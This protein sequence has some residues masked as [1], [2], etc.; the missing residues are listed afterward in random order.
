MSSSTV[1]PGRSRA[2]P[3][4]YRLTTT[5]SNGAIAA[6][7][8]LAPV[9][10]EAA[11]GQDPA[12][13][14][15]VERLDPAV[16]H[17]GRSRSRRPRRSPAG[18][19]RATPAPCRRSRPARS[20]ARRGRDPRSTSPVLSETDSSARRGTGTRASAR[21][22]STRHAPA[23]DDQRVGQEQRD[24]PRQ[25]PVLDGADPVVEGR[26]VVAGQDRHGLLRDDRPTVERR[27]DEVDR[28]AGHGRAVRQRVR[29]GMAARERRQQRRVRVEDPSRRTPPGPPA[30]RSACT[31][32]ARPRRR[33]RPRASRRASRRRRPGRAPSRSPAPPPSRAPGRR[34]RRRRGR[35]RRRAPRDRPPAA[36][37]R[38]FEPAPDTP[39][40]IRPL[41]RR[42]RAAP[43]RSGRR[44]PPRSS[45]TSPTTDRL[46]PERPDRLD[47]RRDGVARQH[48]DHAEPAVERRP[49]LRVVETAERPE[50]AHDRRHR[51]ARRVEPRRET[52]RQRARHVAG[53]AAAGDVGDAVEVEAQRS[54]RGPSREDRLRRRSVSASAGSRRASPSPRA[55]RRRGRVGRGV[56]ERPAEP[57]LVRLARGR[58][59]TAPA[60]PGPARSRSSGGPDEARPRMTSPAR[61][62]EPSMT[63]ARSTTPMQQPDRSKASVGHEVRVLRRLAADQRAAGVATAGRDRADELGDGLRDDPPDGDVVEEGERLGAAAHDVVGA[64]RHEVDA[65]RVEP[66]EGE[67]RS[68]SWCRRRRSR[69]RSAARGSRPGS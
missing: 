59:P 20:R 58:A 34:D 54:R 66:P 57:R 19:R 27:V 68:R 69:R 50:Q 31:R 65:D 52:V 10:G 30:R 42:P 37:A 15:R 38:R 48:D 7:S 14:P 35:S 23:I 46:D 3:N 18:R 12:V 36:S 47:R 11:V 25:Q 32:P 43:R 24:G 45:I 2:A 13:D 55:A 17:L 4:G 56:A 53:Q 49:Q 60:A 21:A 39:T 5:S 51:P 29:D 28:A 61:T 26:H 40:A 6:A 63:S 62:A 8:S 22:R 67:R 33:R 16:E 9:I 1:I 44:R 64:H 41:N